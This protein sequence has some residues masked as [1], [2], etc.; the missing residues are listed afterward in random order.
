[1]RKRTWYAVALL[2]ILGCSGGLVSGGGPHTDTKVRF[3]TSDRC[4]ACHNG[5]VTPSG[6]DV[7]IGFD[8]RSSIMANSSRDPYWQGSV[9]RESIDHPESVAAIEDECSVCHMPIPRFEAKLQG[10]KGEVFSHLPFDA[11]NKG[12]AEAEDGVTCSVCHQIAKEKLG[13]AESF[14]GGFV[15]NPAASN[16]EHPEYGPFAIDAGRQRIMHTS[17][18]GFRP[19]EDAHIRDSALCGTCHTLKTKA[20]GPGGKEIGSLPEQMP[21]PEWLHSDYPNRSTCQSCHMPEIPGEVPITAVLGVPRQGAHQHTFVA[22]NFFMLRMLNLHR[23]DLSVKALPTELT[24]EAERTVAFLQSQSARV[25]VQSVETS[26]DHIKVHVRVQNLTGHKMPTAYPSRRAWLHV[27]IRDARDNKVFESGAL[28][29]DGSIEGNDNDADPA[30]FEPHY[31]EI[32][33]SDQVEIYEPILKDSAGH[34][35]T[36]LLSAV[37]YLKDNRLLPSGFKKETAEADIAVVGDAVEDPNFT[38]A[39]SVVQYS[40]S[41]GGA[42]GPFHVEAELWYQPIGFRWAHNLGPYKAAEPQRFVGY[43][44]SMSTATAL[45]LTRAEAKSEEAARK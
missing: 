14:N 36:G 43:Y 22:G 16:N 32:T 19:T 27:T 37:G 34:V 44:E 1:M 40:V 4:L 42:Q 5:I 7:S 29:A 15:V 11:G 41:T 3:Q 21:Y 26:A 25:S 24:A 20:L 18:A 28:H 30:R 45:L 10:R 2:G 35:T 8:W 31:R 39:G 6:Q 12:N 38:D 9:R 17:S 33:S 23:N 13:T